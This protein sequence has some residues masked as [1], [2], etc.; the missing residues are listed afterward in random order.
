MVRAAGCHLSARCHFHYEMQGLKARIKNNVVVKFVSAHVR[1]ICRDRFCSGN[2]SFWL[3]R[4]FELKQRY[5]PHSVVNSIGF[6]MLQ[7]LRYGPHF[8]EGNCFLIRS[9]RQK[10]PKNVGHCGGALGYRNALLVRLLRPYCSSPV[11]GDCKFYRSKS[12]FCLCLFKLILFLLLLFLLSFS[13]KSG[14]IQNEQHK[15]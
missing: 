15:L 10:V 13:V 8:V 3:L 11:P 14:F 4:T 9:T 5:A 6:G 12:S 1:A 2:Y 7:P